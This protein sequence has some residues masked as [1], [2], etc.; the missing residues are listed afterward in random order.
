[1]VWNLFPFKGDFSLGKSQKSQGTNSGLQGGWVTWVIWCF[2]KNSAWDMMHEQLICS[3]EAANHQLPTAVAFWIIQIVSMAECPSSMQNLMQIC[4]STHSV[5]LHALATQYTLRTIHTVH[6]TQWHLPPALT[7][8][9]KSSLFTHAHSSPLSF[10]ARLHQCCANYSYYINNG[11]TF[12]RQIFYVLFLCSD[13][14]CFMFY[15]AYINLASPIFVWL[16]FPYY[17]SNLL[18][19]T[20]LYISHSKPISG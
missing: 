15:S 20:S 13:L 17:F 1:M 18:L 6:S 2:T 19:L 8:L 4:C 7:S 10:T 5:I 9:V 14:L 11:W 12:Y 16:V 3:D